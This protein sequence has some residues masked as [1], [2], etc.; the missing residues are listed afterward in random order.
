LSIRWRLAV[1]YATVTALLLLP[2]SLVAYG[3]HVRGQYDRLDTSLATTADHFAG[4]FG[5]EERDPGAEEAQRTEP[6][7]FIRLYDSSGAPFGA[8]S[9]PEPPLNALEVRDA[10]DGAA[11]PALARLLPGQAS[12]SSP[13]SFAT[14]RDPASGE[15][16]RLYSLSVS[17]PSSGYVLTWKSLESED[18]SSA[19]LG[20]VILS[21]IVGG[22]AAAGLGTFTVASNVLRPV[23]V[24]TQ[25]ARAIAASRGFS[26][27][28]DDPGR[29]DELGR[30]ARTFNEMLASLEEAY[31]SQQRFVADAAH[32][33]R[34]PLTSI[35]GNVELVTRNPGMAED[36]RAEAVGYL[37]SEARRLARMVDELLTLARADAGQALELRPV[38]LDRILLQAL[39]EVGPLAVDHRLKIAHVE[40][41]QVQGDPDRLKQLILNLIDNSIKYTPARG[42]ITVALKN[43]AA[44]AVLTVEDNGV[45]I[46][47]DDLPHVFERFYRADKA[48]GRDPGGSGLGLAIAAWIVGQHEGDISIES[49]TG[50]GTRVAVRLP[51]A[52]QG[53]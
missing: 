22:V 38:E 12:R 3:L 4:E 6:D 11:Y 35:L 26:R 27:R 13:G 30:L 49:A 28:L 33:L 42:L 9:S 16:V 15:R 39:G 29:G 19:F 41:S 10:K 36:E 43:E 17:G 48:R 32:E 40:P 24:M 46:P 25:T 1:L 44:T 51:L 31:R 2:V 21:F 37:A 50:R 20:K 18:K 8:A 34:A 52:M 7:A 53:A 47:E 14:S 23:T 5:A 45:G